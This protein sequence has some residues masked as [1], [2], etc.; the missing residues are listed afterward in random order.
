MSNEIAVMDAAT[1]ERVVI[2]EDLGKLTPAQRLTYY[3]AV[4]QRLEI[5]PILKPFSY[6]VLNGKLTLYAN[7]NAA[8]QLRRVHGVSIMSIDRD[9]MG[10]LYIVT[11][12]AKDRDGRVDTSTGVVDLKGLTGE[13]LA[14]ALMK[15]ETKAKRRVTLSICGLGWLDETEVETI[16]EARMIEGEVI[17]DE[18]EVVYPNP[19]SDTFRRPTP[20]EISGPRTSADAI[21]AL[22]AAEL[23]KLEEIEAKN[24]E[25]KPPTDK[26]RKALY[27]LYRVVWDYLEPSAQTEAIHALHANVFGRASG[28]EL[29][30]PQVSVLL[31]WLK[32]AD[33]WNPDAIAMK[34][35]KAIAN[36]PL[37]GQEGLF[38]ME[39]EGEVTF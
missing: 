24:W 31:D 28:K 27:G 3:Q 23:E 10:D 13:K 21:M 32:D 17:E 11:A 36:M 1:L 7:R 12:Q 39:A 14:N 19:P 37:D 4:C 18:A 8:E 6:L 2:G 20:R 25:V 26:Q 38:E 35:A 16:P 29:S 15:A 33:S 5:D 30:G 22:K 34:E 9:T